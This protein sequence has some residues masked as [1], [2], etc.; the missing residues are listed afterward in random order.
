MP[1]YYAQLSW[2]ALAGSP[3]YGALVVGLYGL[4][5]VLPPI[6]LGGMLI[7]G[8]ASRRSVSANLVAARVPI[9]AVSS[10]LILAI[11]VFV[12]VLFVGFIELGQI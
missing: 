12:I 5:R 4:G 1:T 11:G 8:G 3:W 10:H 6:V 7:I 9:E 2:V